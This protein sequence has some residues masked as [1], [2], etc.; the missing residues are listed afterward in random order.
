MSTFDKVKE[1][2]IEQLECDEAKVTESASVVDDLGADSLDFVE[3]GMEVEEAFDIEIEESAY[4]DMNTVA[5][6]VSAIDSRL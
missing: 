2:L 6:I 1:I 3:I 4:A 5:D